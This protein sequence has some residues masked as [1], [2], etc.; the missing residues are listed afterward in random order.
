MHHAAYDATS[1]GMLLRDVETVYNGGELP[2][3]RPY[4]DFIKQ[5]RDTPA[6]QTRDFWA[7]YLDGAQPADFPSVPSGYVPSADTTL[8]TD[9]TIP[10][11][12]RPGFTA[13]TMI[14]VAWAMVLGQHAGTSDVVFGE[15]LSGRNGV[16]DA[17]TQGPM[18]TTL[19]IRCVLDEYAGVADV[20]ATMQS[21]LVD[22]IPHQHAGV[23]NIKLA[24]PGPAAACNF[25]CLVTIAPESSAPTNLGLG[26]VPVDV[27]APPAMSHPL[28]VQFILCDNGKLKV[29]VY[30]DHRLVP[31]TQVEKMV[32]QF[33][34]VLGQLCGGGEKNMVADIEVE[35]EEAEVEEAG[36][37]MNVE[38]EIETTGASTAGF[39]PVYGADATGHGKGDVLGALN[40]E[41]EDM[42]EEI[43]SQEG[44]SKPGSSTSEVMTESTGSAGEAGGNLEQV[45]K[46]LWADV[47]GMQPEEIS[48][49]DNFFQLGGDS[50][51]SMRLST[52]AERRGIKI[53]VADIFRH[54][55]LEELCE[56][57]APVNVPNQVAEAREVDGDEEEDDVPELATEAAAAAA[58]IQD[59]YEPLGVIKHLGLDQE[60]VIETV[61]QQL[62][63]FPGD[64]EDIYP[65]TDYQAWAISHGLMRSRGNTNYFLFRLHGQLDT[66]RLEQAC[67]KMVASN[68]ILRTLFTTIRGQV[69]QVVVRSYQIEFLRYGSE[70]SADDN[71]I[72]YLVEQDA[73]RSAYLSQSIVRF[74]LVLHADGHYVLIMRM[75]HA[76]YDGMSMPLLIQ[77]LERCYNGQDPKQRPSFGKFIQGATLREEQAINFWANMLEGS[78]M[79][80]IVEHSG[81]SHKHNV[82][83]IRTRTLPPIPVNVAGMS[84]ATLVKA[85]WAL[86]LAK[87][88]GQRDIVFGNLIFGRNLPVSSRWR[89]C[90]TRRS[91]SAA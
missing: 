41:I 20:L 75:S 84:Q 48:S 58:A 60:E 22:M 25:G 2:A 83:T 4:R 29:S 85:A 66:F 51:A 26:L 77:D 90:L 16:E 74:K 8:E 52:A 24:G 56:S 11:I 59:H 49:A 79:T 63:V 27:G 76:Q 40:G 91:A 53:S 54:P 44:L 86:V 65:A 38:R 43:S 78:A 45:M 1:L 61:C 17:E 69:M 62:S 42:L 13:S 68:P 10:S 70:H 72:N 5:L 82:D 88:S 87:M 71:F 31:A 39:T 30:H 21:A 47:L 28:S 14:R 89:P 46:E 18:I 55:T 32:A 15:T 3:R 12:A 80:E 34:R 37:E 64:V 6:E 9:V 7:K 19:P 36:M 23:Q 35:G 33:V 57:A 67:R 50:M 81:P 73:Q